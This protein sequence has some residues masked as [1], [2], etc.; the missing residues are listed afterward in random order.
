MISPIAPIPS[1]NPAP[2]VANVSPGASNLRSSIDNPVVEP[3]RS[4]SYESSKG[5]TS[6]QANQKS[7]LLAGSGSGVVLSKDA[8]MMSRLM[9]EL[10]KEPPIDQEKVSKIRAQIASGDYRLDTLSL[11]REIMRLERLINSAAAT[12]KNQE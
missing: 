5:S 11:A 1:A 12:P 4:A 8:E 6:E 7:G 9:R 2:Y 10:K 3:S